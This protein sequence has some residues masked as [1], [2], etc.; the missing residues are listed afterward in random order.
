MGGA[1]YAGKEVDD[2][3]LSS[4]GIYTQPKGL[5]TLAL[6]GSAEATAPWAVLFLF[7]LSVEDYNL[8]R[9]VIVLPKTLDL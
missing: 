5:M 2:T 7:M 9:R 3:L 1:T 4:R 8:L 6:L